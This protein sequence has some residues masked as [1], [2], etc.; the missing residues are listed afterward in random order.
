M[1]RNIGETLFDTTNVILLGL[2]TIATLYPFLHVAFASISSPSEL[3]GHSGLLLFP[4]G[5]Q[6]EAYKLVLSNNL[7][8]TGYKNTLIYVVVGTTLNIIVTS[9][10]AYALSRRGVMLRNHVMMFVVFTMFFSGGLIPTYLMIKG[11]GLLN[12]MGAIVLPGLIS[13]MNL[14]IMRTYFQSIPESL[15][16]SAKLD[17]AGDWVILLKIIIPLSMPVI[18]V[19]ILYYGVGHWNAW[20]NAS[21]YLNKSELFPLQLVLRNILIGNSTDDMMVSLGVDQKGQDMSEVIK[22]T[23]IMVA[24]IPVLLVYPFLQKYFA[25]GVMIGAIKG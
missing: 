12:T 1:K 7:I 11:L 16:E 15:E 6:W 20:F 5:F 23:T 13:T 4:R 21:I 24:T 19:M 8:L 18:S 25:K 3:A 9:L 22:Y 10:M 14:I 2:L 17:G